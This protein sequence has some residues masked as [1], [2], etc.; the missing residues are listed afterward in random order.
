MEDNNFGQNTKRI[1]FTE[2]DHRHAQLIVKLK[3]D[4]MTQA[5]FFR[6]MIT[7]YLEDDERIRSY[8]IDN[9]SLS[10]KK[11]KKSMKLFEE[12]KKTASSLGLND[13]QVDNIFDMIAEEFP[14]L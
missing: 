13:E 3:T 2:N 8:V 5:K 1:V 9:S 12:G 7:G 10:K 4:G 6:Q 14:D 11:I